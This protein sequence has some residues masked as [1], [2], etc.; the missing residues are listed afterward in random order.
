MMARLD[1]ALMTRFRVHG[2]KTSQ[3]RMMEPLNIEQHRKMAPPGGADA[4]A[5][6]PPDPNSPPITPQAV[7]AA[8]SNKQP[9]PETKESLWT[10][11]WVILSFWV[12]VA[13]LG[14]PVWWKTTAIYRAELPLQDMSNWADG[15]VRFP[16]L[17]SRMSNDA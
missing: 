11:R 13:C 16:L 15:K 3:P 6:V 4:P 5:A 10:R 17:A 7:G 9:P 14:L 12:V 2:A 1:G 8:S